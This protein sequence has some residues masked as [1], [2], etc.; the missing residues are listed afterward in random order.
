MTKSQKLLAI[1]IASALSISSCR[2][3]NESN[4]IEEL[5]ATS[6]VF[7]EDELLADPIAMTAT[8]AG[9]AI[10]NDDT[11]DTLVDLFD[12]EGVISSRFI[13]KGNGPNEVLRML[14]MQ[15][16]PNTKN[17]YAIDY[18]NKSILEVRGAEEGNPI[19][20]PFIKFSTPENQN[21]IDVNSTKLYL[22]SYMGV[23]ADGQ[24]LATNGTNSGMIA[25]FDKSLQLKDIIIPYPDKDKTDPQLTDWA[26]INHLRPKLTVSPDGK[27]A[28]VD[29]YTAD[30][31]AFLTA[32][33]DS[34]KYTTF[35]DA[36]PND[37]Y[38]VQS[39]PDFVQAA[40]TQKTKKYS[41]ETSLSN[42]YA[43]QLYVGQSDEDIM[44]TDFYKDTKRT[45]S[46][47]VRVFDKEGRHLK[48]IHLDQPAKTIAVSPDDKTL[49]SLTESSQFGNRI[50]KYEL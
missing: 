41:L 23:T 26:N 5:E 8:N 49:Y 38:L 24:V 9:V 14:Q 11:A 16:D 4:T 45:G 31:R 28:V 12:A 32:A 18:N 7:I 46:I 33:D 3:K 1:A 2:N 39:G 35:E 22:T 48:N 42:N 43:Y 37:L 30:I 50:L 29:I 19:I 40:I 13:A 25:V 10:I 15:Y 21:A 20:T 6:T 34:I 17:F 27:F 47:L 44:N 36:Y